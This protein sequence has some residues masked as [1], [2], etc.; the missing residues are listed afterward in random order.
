MPL[1]ACPPSPQAQWAKSNYVAADVVQI[2]GEQALE[3]I[4]SLEKGSAVSG[5][6]LR[7]MEGMSTPE[8]VLKVLSKVQADP[9]PTAS[10]L[11]SVAAEVQDDRRWTWL[12]CHPDLTPEHIHPS[13][14]M[15]PPC[16]P[17][18]VQG[19]GYVI[20][21][22]GR[23]PAGKNVNGSGIAPGLFLSLGRGPLN[24]SCDKRLPV[25][26][27]PPPFTSC[28]LP[29]QSTWARCAP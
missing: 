24:R 18:V 3:A 9:R 5:N 27:H 4:A 7:C 25:M 16:H 17:C 15:L 1:T 13:R 26:T 20:G 12:L 23:H 22:T 10:L 29:P 21:Y 28:S 8:D 14:S 11:R 6:T 19:G 2:G